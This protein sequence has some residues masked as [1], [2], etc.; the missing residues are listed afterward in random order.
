MIDLED[1]TSPDKQPNLIAQSDSSDPV[2]AYLELALKIYL[3]I[4]N[5]GR[6]IHNPQFDDE[7]DRL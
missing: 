5:E 4:K 2:T 7:S 3:R 1:S 6:A